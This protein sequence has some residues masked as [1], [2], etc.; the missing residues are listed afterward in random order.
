MAHDDI[1]TVQTIDLA[2]K[3]NEA[4]DKIN[5]NFHLLE[6][7]VGG[8]SVEEVN[9]LIL[10]KINELNDDTGFTQEE[11]RTFL[12]STTLD[13]GSNK[14]LYSNHFQDENELNA[15]DAGTYHG[16][17]AHVHSTGFAYYAHDNQWVKL[18]KHGEVG[19][20]NDLTDVEINSV[21]TGQ[22]LKWDGVKWTNL[23]DSMSGGDG[24]GPAG[25]STFTATIYTRASSSPTTPFGGSYD[26]TSGVLTV[27]T[28]DSSGGALTETWYDEIP[29]PDGDKDIYACNYRFID[30]QSET[31]LIGGGEWS[32][33]YLIGGPPVDVNSG[34][35][36]AQLYAYKRSESSISTAP[37][38]GSFN[39][40]TKE[41]TAP[42]G[43]NVGPEEGVGELYVSTGIASTLGVSANGDG[44]LVDSTINWSAPVIAS[45]GLN[46]K[47]AAEKAVYFAKTRT[48]DSNGNIEP[49]TKPTGGSY[50][51]T[52]NQ[53]DD[54]PTGWSASPNGL[55]EE[56]KDVW[57]STYPFVVEGDTG[58][59]VAVDPPG[60]SDPVP[61]I[62]ETISTYRASLYTR[63][64]RELD[65]DGNI[66]PP[67]A[68]PTPNSVIYNFDSN[69][70]VKQ[71]DQNDDTDLV[72]GTSGSWYEVPVASPDPNNPQDLWETTT[73]ASLRGQNGIDNSLTFTAPILSSVPG[74]QGPPGVVDPSDINI[75]GLGLIDSGYLYYHGES[76]TNPGAPTATKFVFTSLS[77][78]NSNVGMGYFEGLSPAAGTN[79][80]GWSLSPSEDTNLTGSIWACRYRVV[81]DAVDGDEAT[82]SNIQIG[83]PFRN[84]NFNGL[85]T[86]QNLNGALGTDET[87]NITSIDGGKITT[88]TILSDSIRTGSLTVGSLEGNINTIT[89]FSGS[90]TR[91][92]GPSSAG[93]KELTTIELPRNAVDQVVDAE[94]TTERKIFQ[95]I[96]TISMAFSGLFATDTAYVKLLFQQKDANTQDTNNWPSTWTTI[97][98]QR[99]K[100]G[101]G[102]NSWTIIPVNGSFAEGAIYDSRFKIEIKMMSDNGQNNTDKSRTGVNSWS[103]TVSGL[104]ASTTDSTALSAYDP[105][106]SA[107]QVVSGSDDGGTSALDATAIYNEFAN[108]VATVAG[109]TT[110]TLYDSVF[111]WNPDTGQFEDANGDAVTFD[112]NLNGS[113]IEP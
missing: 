6:E 44:D 28:T 109:Q 66:I 96:P 101:G 24:S 4:V 2:D 86:F 51:F 25:T 103:G 3:I 56:G 15:I 84:Y 54:V 43:W 99:H 88:G 74:E 110:A 57:S 52:T 23:A 35:S 65:V 48:Y 37:S 91:T 29:A 89:A 30:L 92:W 63:K 104:I 98:T 107:N 40:T 45:T 58:T 50:N 60:W 47:S 49:P 32:T 106:S 10:A 95:H 59:V 67:S 93:Y 61:Y 70:F 38:G 71:S 55:V 22:V 79:S 7:G 16:M 69:R 21:S 80:N 34:E 41:Y 14:I 64:A 111:S 78:N 31:N 42:T 26:F 13:L 8:L 77:E 11:I 9:A 5:E 36:I 108:T 53:M 18:A 94:G 81:A 39:F 75:T 62:V 82:G 46:G 113:G 83:A 73:V 105:T 85:V 97:Q 12:A 19:A 72:A 20:L 68:I 102:G 100:T 76:S 112:I 17:F 90:G 33:P 87:G 27:P 1:T